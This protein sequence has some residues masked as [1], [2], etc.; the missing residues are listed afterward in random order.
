MTSE[1]NALI[2]Y[3]DTD[4]S[5]M[6][7]DFKRRLE[8]YDPDVTQKTKKRMYDKMKDRKHVMI[9]DKL[10]L[11]GWLYHMS[12]GNKHFLNSFYISKT[13][14][15]PLPTFLPTAGSMDKMHMLNLNKLLALN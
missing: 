4:P 1:A 8:L 6:A 10:S 2:S 7:K 12:D 3:T 15:G 5:P 11:I 14:G 9:S 13:G